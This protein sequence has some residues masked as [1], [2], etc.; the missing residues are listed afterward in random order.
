MLSRILPPG[1][2]G[3]LDIR[4]SSYLLLHLSCTSPT[5]LLPTRGCHRTSEFLHEE[6]TMLVFREVF[7][8]LLVGGGIAIIAP[9]QGLLEI[10]DKP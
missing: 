9:D 4:T 8:V 6:I 10:R 1:T 7:R 5:T 2:L 3:L